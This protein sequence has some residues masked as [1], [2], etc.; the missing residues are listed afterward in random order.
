MT[1]ST[2]Q[3]ATASDI[4]ALEP[5][6][7]VE[8]SS[9]LRNSN[10]TERTTSASAFVLLKETQL[11]DDL[12]ACRIKFD[13]NE[14]AGTAHGRVYKNDVAIGTDQTNTTES[15]ITFSQD[16]TG[17]VSSDSLQIYAYNTVATNTTFVRNMRFYYDLFVTELA[18]NETTKHILDSPLLLTTDPTV[19]MVNQDP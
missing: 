15:Y 7:V 16:F 8:A 2:G 4:I 3:V 9:T 19:S 17:F 6:I 5:T 1:I 10:N 18:E 11:N 13:L 14:D 12:A